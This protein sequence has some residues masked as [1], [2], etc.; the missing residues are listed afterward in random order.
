MKYI[1]EWSCRQEISPSSTWLAN[2]AG[3]LCTSPAACTLLLHEQTPAWGEDASPS[4]SPPRSHTCYG[5]D[6]RDHLFV[7]PLVRLF[8]LI[9]DLWSSPEVCKSATANFVVI[10]ISKLGQ[11][12]VN[13]DFCKSTWKCSTK[14]S[15]L[16][17]ATFIKAQPARLQWRILPQRPPV[18]G[19]TVVWAPHAQTPILCR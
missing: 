6:S 9:I 10:S 13:N 7:S 14:G 11:H 16:A 17:P 8:A 18:P 19:Q 5:S 12:F 2:A 3:S 4:S 1:S 15:S